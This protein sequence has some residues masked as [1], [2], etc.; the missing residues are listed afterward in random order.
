MAQEAFDSDGNLKDAKQ[1]AEVERIS[2]R[3]V[4]VTTL[5]NKQ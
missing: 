1:L 5:L 2:K 3:L 4:E